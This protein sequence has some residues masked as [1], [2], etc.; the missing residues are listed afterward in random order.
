VATPLLYSAVMK[1]R[2]AWSRPSIAIRDAEQA[3]LPALVT[4]KGEGTEGLHRDRLHDAQA[5][6]VR[7]LVLVRGQEVIGF[8]LL[9]F[10]RPAAWS[11]AND[12]QHLP[13]L[14]DLLIAEEHR[15]QGYGS[16]FVREIE[17]EAAAAGHQQ[18]YLAVEPAHNTPAYR[19]YQRLGYQQLQPEPYLKAWEFSDSEG[20]KHCGEDWIVDMTKAL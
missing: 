9:V 14:V 20:N 16:A 18:L 11:D 19:L 5:G 4:I 7:Y 1:N 6:G 15:G 3:D 10:R 17:R 12:T 13:Q 8:A 2:K